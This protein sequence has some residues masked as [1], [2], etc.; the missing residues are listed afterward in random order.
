MG[1]YGGA[2]AGAYELGKAAYTG[3][4]PYSQGKAWL[5]GVEDALH[6]IG[7]FFSSIPSDPAPPSVSSQFALDAARTARAN[8]FGGSTDNLPG[9]TADDL[10]IKSVRIDAA[11][12]S[13]MT[14]PTATQDVR[15]VN[16]Q[17]PNVTVYATATITGVADSKEAVAAAATD[18]GNQIAAGTEGLFS[19]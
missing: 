9:K 3:D 2:G 6:S 19:D 12:L 16:P 8:G 17:P 18:L 5:P 7:K 14:R 4:T 11:S 15:V 13:E 10:G 1:I